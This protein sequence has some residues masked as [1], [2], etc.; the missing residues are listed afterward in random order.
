MIIRFAIWMGISF[1]KIPCSQFLVTMGAREMLR[2]PCLAQS[3]YHLSD[4][5]FVAGVATTFLCCIDSLTRHIGLEI[6]KHRIQLVLL[7]MGWT[8]LLRN[9]FSSFVWLCVRWI[10]HSLMLMASRINLKQKEKKDF[11]YIKKGKN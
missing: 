2:M 8:Q 6:S 10:C 7:W 4:Y 5:G 1:K 3:C 9:A 11:S